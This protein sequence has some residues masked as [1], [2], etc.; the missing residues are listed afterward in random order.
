MQENQAE[1]AL[2]LEKIRHSSEHILTYVMLQDLGIDKITPAM[3]PAIENGFYFDFSHLP[4]VEISVASFPKWEKAAKKIIQTNW[5]LKEFRVDIPEAARF[6]ATNSFKQE[7]LADL[8]VEKVTLFSLAPKEKN[9]ALQSLA[10]LD[11]ESAFKAGYFVDL[12]KGP[13]V[14]K[15]G[16]IGAFKLLKIAA[17]Y[18]RGDEKNQQLTRIYGTAF[19]T[20]AELDQYLNWLEESKKRDHKRIGKVQD[21]FS[22]HSISPGAVFWHPKGLVLWDTLEHFGQNLRKKYGYL[23]IKTP[24]MA[25]VE[26]W[27][28]SGHWD[29]YKDDMF[30]FLADDE[31]YCLKPMDC[32]FNIKIYQTK[33][34]SYRDLP[35]RFTEIGHVFRNEQS[36]ELNGLF[37][38]REITQDDSHL[39]VREDQ[40]LSEIES[41]LLMVK[42]YYQKL[43]LQPEY[44][45]STRPDDFMGEIATW[46]RAEA[47]LIEALTKQGISYQL[48]EKD[49]A[50][51]GPKIDVNIKDSLGRSWQVATIQLDFQMPGRFGCE[52]IDAAGKVQVPVMIHAAIFGSYERM[53]G[54][55]LEHYAG[56]LPLWLAP[57]Q[58]QILPIADRHLAYAQKVQAAL[59]A[60]NFRAEVDTRSERLNA[61][62]RDAQEQQIPVMIVVGDGEID[63]ETVTLRWRDQNQQEEVSL[64]NLAT[65]LAQ[66]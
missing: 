34:R 64:A 10:D 32:P 65:K 36:G 62:I 2:Q 44:F 21:L 61:K 11:F 58:V 53:I 47:N 17:A 27:K 49:G 5:T 8:N 45:L 38:V 7:I 37:R 51:Y 35:M 60:A 28:I 43:G 30:S 52:Y 39:L 33:Q 42:E 19:K 59:T 29:H 31:Q 1:Q 12:C 4:D 26:M 20:Q 63:R 66:D 13:H 50:F 6:F 54:I 3:G 41:L 46:N 9:D 48:K 56:R 14:E 40:I 57:V 55:L 24:E 25:K 23:K 22:F 16:E 15:T 18:W